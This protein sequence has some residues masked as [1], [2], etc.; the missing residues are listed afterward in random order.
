MDTKLPQPS[1]PKGM[2][3]LQASLMN[4]RRTKKH[5]LHHLFWEC[6]LRCNVSCLHCGSDCRAVAETK[7]MPLEDFLAVLDDISTVMDPN[8]IVVQTTGG[9]PLVRKDIVECGRAIRERG[10]HWA[11]VS[12]GLLLDEQMG[13]R[14]LDAGLESIAISMD[15][16][17]NDHNWM[18]GHKLSFACAERA[19]KF[20]V[21]KNL[22]W[23]VITCVN[24][25]TIGYLEEFKRYL[26]DLGV[27]KWRIFTIVPMGRA[28]LYPELQLGDEQFRQVMDFIAATRKEKSIN[29]SFS[30]EDFLGDYEYEV[31]NSPF[32][33]QSGVNVASILADGSISGCL[34]MR[35]NYHQGNIYKDR[36]TDV[37][38]N[39]FQEYRNREWMHTDQCS[40][41]KMWDFCLGNGLHLRDDEGKLM[42]CKY[43]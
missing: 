20:L 23:D 8:T 4:E 26:I 42:L 5:K 34:S 12:N 37:W 29:L 21:G 1:F 19:V 3:L 38:E 35:S 14:L 2:R 24:Q 10:F 30:C 17:E 6:T 9:E 36:F 41:C 40:D 18:R 13:I 39:K 32:F 7:D 28:A 16:F 25:K 22:V 11:M 15:G 27:K 31:R 43:K 33:C